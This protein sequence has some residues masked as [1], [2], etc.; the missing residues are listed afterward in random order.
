M[1]A[2]NINGYTIKRA[3]CRQINYT[4]HHTNGVPVAG[5][6]RKLCGY[7]VTGGHLEGNA[8]KWCDT[9]REAMEYCGVTP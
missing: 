2:H 7:I 9:L 4:S 1:S 5:K 3:T 6:G 8:S